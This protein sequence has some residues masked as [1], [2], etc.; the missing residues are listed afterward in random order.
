M[1][2]PAIVKSAD[3]KRMGDFVRKNPGMRVEI[4]KNGVLIRVAPDIPANHS[5]KPVAR[6]ED[7]EL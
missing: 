1:T 2:N 5:E 6:Y 4:E 7:F 3:L